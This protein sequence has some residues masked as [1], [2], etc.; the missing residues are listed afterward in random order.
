MP[1]DKKTIVDSVLKTGRLM[2]THEAPL[3]AGFASEIAAT[4]QK[5]CFL[6]LE[7]P[8]AVRCRAACPVRPAK[9]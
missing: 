6:Q 1:W 7:A 2:V 3:T 4:V 5:D 8:I 9:A